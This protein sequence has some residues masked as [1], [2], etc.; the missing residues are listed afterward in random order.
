MSCESE[1]SSR[2]GTPSMRASARRRATVL[3]SPLWPR[4]ENGCT[5]M[6]DGHVLV[7]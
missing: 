7:E 5:R 4:T 1:E 2:I 3:I 6:N